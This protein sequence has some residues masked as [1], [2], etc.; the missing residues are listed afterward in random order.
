MRIVPADGEEITDDRLGCL[1]LDTCTP[2]T[3]RHVPDEL[4]LGAYAAWDK[5]RDHIH[6]EWTFFTDPANVQPKVSSLLRRAAQHLL[7]NPPPEV[8]PENLSAIVESLE[9]P[10]SRRMEH[11]IRE[12]FT[13]ESDDRLAVSV[14]IIEKVLEL[15][16]QPFRA[17]D[18]LP[19]IDHDEIQLIAWTAIDRE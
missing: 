18:A 19:P 17:P 16:L 15:G 1:R 13:P 6:A 11:S 9:A 4:R 8:T 14:A 5:A 10:L 2:D 3:E 12:A 7:T